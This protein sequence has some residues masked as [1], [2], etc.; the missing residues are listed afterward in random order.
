MRFRSWSYRFAEQVLNSKFVIKKE[1]EEIVKSINFEPRK[2]TRPGL[3]K[4]FEKEFIKMGWKPQQRVSDEL[5]AKIDFIKERVGIEV[6]FVHPSFIG[7]DLLKFQTMSYSNLDV[8]D[9]GV[10]ILITKN[11]SQYP[12]FMGSITFEKVQNYLPHFRSAI[13]VP[14]WVVGLEE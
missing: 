6:A 7:L 3:N 2:T 13:Q 5:A 1:I 4:S 14:I 11:I 8:I 9:V 10:Y 12:Q